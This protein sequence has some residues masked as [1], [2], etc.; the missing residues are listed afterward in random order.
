MSYTR[1]QAEEVIKDWN[2]YQDYENKLYTVDKEFLNHKFGQQL[3]VGKW[4]K[5]DSYNSKVC[6]QGDGVGFGI[7]SGVWSRNWSMRNSDWK[8]MTD[9][10]V[11]EF[12]KSE[13]EKRYKV[14]D[15]VES[16][17]SKNHKMI[18]DQRIKVSDGY[19]FLSGVPVLDLTTGEWADVIKKDPI[20]EKIEK[21]ENELQT[22]KN[23]YN[24]QNK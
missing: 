3:E 20:A 19:C 10:E 14:R 16:V 2:V 22:L 7:W 24:E 1:E 18:Y 11:R 8:P 9:K 13:C 4:Y 23:K 17:W 6:Y 15:V 21:L 5:N 12:L